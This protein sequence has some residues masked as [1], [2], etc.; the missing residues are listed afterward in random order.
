[1][2]CCN[3]GQMEIASTYDRLPRHCKATPGEKLVTS[4]SSLGTVVEYRVR[5][6]ADWNCSIRIWK[7]AR[8]TGTACFSLLA[9]RCQ[10]IRRHF[11]CSIL[12]AMGSTRPQ[13]DGPQ[14]EANVISWRE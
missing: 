13:T 6:R 1:M 4:A 2:V 9:A 8:F 7:L 10:C 14:L 11:S 5:L 3:H 12:R